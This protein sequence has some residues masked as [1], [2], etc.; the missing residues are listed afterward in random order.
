MLIY[1]KAPLFL[2]AEAVATA[3]YTQNRSLIRI[4]HRKTPY[5]LLHDRK[6]DLSYL[7]VF[8]ALC[9]PTN[10]SED[11]GK[12]KAKV[13]PTR[14]DWDILLQPLFDEYF[15]PPPCVDHQIPDVASSVSAILTGSPSSTSV[16]QD[17]PSPI[18]SQTPQESPSYVIPP[19]AKKSDYDIEVA[20][21]DHN[22]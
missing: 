4:R 18:I 11:L 8:G 1:A 7:H 16:D 12:L 2:W 3:C 14:D 20:H 10:D 17:A 6:P 5:E 19:G 9:Y 21:M 15:S 22:P 13:D